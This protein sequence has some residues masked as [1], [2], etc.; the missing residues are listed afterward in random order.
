LILNDNFD[1]Y[2]NIKISTNL[3]TSNKKM[4][5][6]I[7][8]QNLENN[9]RYNEDNAQSNKN[10][11]QGLT[12]IENQ[13]DS[14]NNK[15]SRQNK[16]SAKSKESVSFKSQ[17]KSVDI[18][19]D[20]KKEKINNIL[21]GLK[22]KYNYQLSP[23]TDLKSFG[24][25]TPGPGQYYNPDIK[26]GQGQ[27]LRY[28]NL[29]KDPEHDITLKYKLLKDNYYQS[30]IGPGTYNLNLGYEH[31]SY[32]QNPK[33]FLSKLERGPLFKITESVGPAYYNPDNSQIKKEIHNSNNIKKRSK[34]KSKFILKTEP[35]FQPNNL[36]IIKPSSN[37]NRGLSGKIS[38]KGH[39]NFSWKGISD[40][41]GLGIKFSK[42]E[43]KEMTKDDK[44]VYKNQEFNFD[45]QKKLG[46]K[47]NKFSKTTKKIIQKEISEYNKLNK[48]LID[49]VPKDV[50]L[51]GN[52]LPGPCYYNYVNDSIEGDIKILNKKNK[53]NLLHK[54]K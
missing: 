6:L 38:F 27:N 11:N 49:Y 32:S 45:N 18:K 8:N 35:F 14:N 15:T 28:N 41:S 5:I 22:L 20:E 48:P 24:D 46:N 42:N 7:D 39:K 44:I 25:L 33:T 30:K 31:K 16:V 17:N 34:D 26:I 43:N 19:K 23:Y 1:F 50:V 40:F 9:Q 3:L 37:K 12:E 53:K 2:K 21:G 54:W 51:K 4:E 36:K 47:K 52:H 29:F 13:F 10:L